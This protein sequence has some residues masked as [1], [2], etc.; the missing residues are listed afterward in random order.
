MAAFIEA[1]MWSSRFDPRDGLYISSCQP[2]R[3]FEP[4][5]RHTLTCPSHQEH[6]LMWSSGKVA[7]Y[8][9]NKLFSGSYRT[10][11]CSLF[12]YYQSIHFKSWLPH[13][14]GD[15]PQCNVYCDLDD[16]LL[17]HCMLREQ[18]LLNQNFQGPKGT[19]PQ[20]D[21]SF[22]KYIKPLGANSQT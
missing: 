9:L 8:K 15:Y 1:R 19:I 17:K 2:S 22:D 10:N 5:C 13:F 6:E 20:Y 12:F 14:V 18:M 7:L 11:E 4:L 16:D 3:W 21:G